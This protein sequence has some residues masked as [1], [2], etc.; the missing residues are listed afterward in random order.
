MHRYNESIIQKETKQVQSLLNQSMQKQAQARQAFQ[1]KLKKSRMDQKL[2]LKSES[3][4]DEALEDFEH[5]IGKRTYSAAKTGHIA[6]T[7]QIL[8][9]KRARVQTKSAL[10]QAVQSEIA[11]STEK[12]DP[13][14]RDHALEA[15]SVDELKRTFVKASQDT[16][17][18][19]DLRG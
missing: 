17:K 18:P 3:A 7:K 1:E 6:Q 16:R 8:P 14:I 13:K 19:W 9:A 10:K 12:F 4:I 2:K 5:L 11:Q 15:A